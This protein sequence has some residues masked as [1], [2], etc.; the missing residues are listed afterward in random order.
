[1]RRPPLHVLELRGRARKSLAGGRGNPAKP[2]SR[3]AHILPSGTSV[4]QVESRRR[5]F[6]QAS[7]RERSVGRNCRRRSGVCSLPSSD[8]YDATR[9]DA[10]C[11]LALSAMAETAQPGRWRGESPFRTRFALRSLQIASL[12]PRMSHCRQLRTAGQ[13]DDGKD[14]GAPRF[15]ELARKGEAQ[16]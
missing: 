16:T 11:L 12:P 2:Q 5:R 6:G 9:P 14:A 10:R 8:G 1:M 13:E 7:S 15:T 3:P 4:L